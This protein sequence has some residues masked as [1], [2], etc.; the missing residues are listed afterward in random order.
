MSKIGNKVRQSYRLQKMVPVV[1]LFTLIAL[2]GIVVASPAV[3]GIELAS[4]QEISSPTINVSNASTDVGNSTSVGVTM[5]EAPDGLAGYN[6]VLSVKNDSVATITDAE[7]DEKFALSEVNVSDNGTT[8]MVNLRAVDIKENIQEGATNISLADVEI[9][10]QTAGET[11][12]EVQEIR[13]ID[14]DTGAA[15]DVDTNSGQI[16]VEKADN[17]NGNTT[18]N[19]DVALDREHVTAG[20]ETKAK[21]ILSE[22]PEGV[23]GFN[24]TIDVD[25][26]EVT[27]AAASAGDEFALSVADSDAN[28]AMIRGVD[29]NRNVEAGAENVTLGEVHIRSATNTDGTAEINIADIDVL[30]NN[31]AGTIPVSVSG[32]TLEVHDVEPVVYD[33][34]PTDIDADGLYADINGDG[35]LT[36][37]DVTVLFQQFNSEAIQG[38]D[39][40]DFDGN[41]RV[42]YNDI[43]A[44]SDM[45]AAAE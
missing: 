4:A 9:E 19:L 7:I 29:L 28:A 10:G 20:D 44:L 31:K 15:I 42:S 8:M 41:G 6:V 3:G 18:M 24:I 37:K 16:T 23:A 27:I 40:Y 25:G 36:Q 17:G 39:E 14:D 12:L 2:V 26:E 33:R 11:D 30:E 13:Q 21:V 1:R 43:V 32:A 35:E 22:A 45:V 38:H 5:S 34:V